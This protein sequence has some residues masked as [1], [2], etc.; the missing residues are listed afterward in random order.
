MAQLANA[1]QDGQDLQGARSVMAPMS[2]YALTMFYSFFSVDLCINKNPVPPLSGPTG[3]SLAI[4][5]QNSIT[6]ASDITQIRAQIAFMVSQGN[7]QNA[8]WITR[9]V[10]ITFTDTCEGSYSYYVD[11]VF[12]VAQITYH[13]D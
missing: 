12:K 7:Q 9:Y 10:L 2:F 8:M 13:N 6:M 1:L 4:V 11:T 3:R 5:I